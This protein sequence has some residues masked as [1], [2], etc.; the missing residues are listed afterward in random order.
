MS[1]L[2]LERAPGGTERPDFVAASAVDV[3]HENRRSAVVVG[4]ED[5][6]G[7]FGVGSGRQLRSWD[8]KCPR[9]SF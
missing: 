8:R 4:R 6:G 7:G 9:L 1:R 3:G 5:I 2:T